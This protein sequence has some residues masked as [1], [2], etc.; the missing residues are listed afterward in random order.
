[1]WKE[2]KARMEFPEQAM[3]NSVRDRFIN[4]QLK[5]VWS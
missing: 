4:N 3:I 2:L 5:V 1:M